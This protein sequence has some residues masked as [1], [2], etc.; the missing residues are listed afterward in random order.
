[1]THEPFHHPSEPFEYWRDTPAEAGLR[2][3]LESTSKLLGDSR[4][5]DGTEIMGV[6]Q[7]SAE[8][9]ESIG[10]PPEATHVLFQT[11]EQADH[12]VFT[13][14]YEQYS[15]TLIGRERYGNSDPA[16]PYYFSMWLP[17]SRGNIS[18]GLRV[19]SRHYG[20]Y[21]QE[22]TPSIAEKEPPSMTVISDSGEE[23]ISVI[24]A[25][26]GDVDP[27]RKDAFISLLEAMRLEATSVLEDGSLQLSEEQ[28][29]LITAFTDNVLYPC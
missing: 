17:T 16:E 4:H 20:G 26:I 9:R 28:M 29:R 8:A 22:V 2:E 12:R 13:H 10:V 24:G 19:P 27:R 25:F 23:P 3:V 7:I 14:D 21:A 18:L 1:M 5:F 11:Y 15:V 6:G